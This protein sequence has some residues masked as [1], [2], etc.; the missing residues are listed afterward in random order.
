[1][2][3]KKKGERQW[4]SESS[5]LSHIKNIRSGHTIDGSFNGGLCLPFPSKNY[6]GSHR[7]IIPGWHKNFNQVAIDIFEIEFKKTE[8]DRAQHIL[9]SLAIHENLVRYFSCETV[10]QGDRVFV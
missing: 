9:K 10:E 7:K 3:L 6:E 2:N 1:M 8:V 4:V 5:Y